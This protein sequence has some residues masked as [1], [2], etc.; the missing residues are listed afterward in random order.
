MSS[1][2]FKS[3]LCL[4]ILGLLVFT[5]CEVYTGGPGY[6]Y[7]GYY[8]PA[9]Y[10]YYGGYWGPDFYIFGEHHHGEAEHHFSRR[11]Y[12]SRNAARGGGPSKNQPGLT[13]LAL[14]CDCCGN[15]PAA[16]A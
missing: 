6:G 12:E 9:Y 14:V 8:G 3:L 7:S 11:G 10:G 15:R 2:G 4:G 5:G 1:K 13:S 16:S